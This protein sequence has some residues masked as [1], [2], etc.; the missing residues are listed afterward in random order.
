MKKGTKIFLVIFIPIAI[1][2]AGLGGYKI[3]EV[4][5]DSKIRNLD[6]PILEFPV[7]NIDAIHIIWGYGYHGDNFHGGIDYGCNDSVYIKAPCDLQVF[8][9]ET[10][11]YTTDPVL[12]QTKVKMEFNAR[13]VIE[14]SFESWAQNETYANYQRDAINVTE[15]QFIQEG[16][17]IGMLLYHGEGTHIDFSMSDIEEFICP[18]QYFSNEAKT[19]FDAL[20]DKCGFGDDSWYTT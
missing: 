14:I 13:F 4:I 5:R 12:W 7:V 17:I 11:I 20:W 9:I 10:W 19:I 18:Y 2:G 16:D 1:I 3:Y 6:A 15:G 8:Y